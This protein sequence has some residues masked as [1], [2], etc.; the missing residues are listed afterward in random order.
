M[1]FAIAGS[2]AIGCRFGFMLHEIGIDVILIDK[3]KEHV[4]QIRKNGLKVNYNNEDKVAQIPIYY[5]E[6]VHDE[7]DVVIVFTKSMGLE[8]MLRDIKHILRKNTKIV[9]L[10]NGIGHEKV[11]QK[12]V[13][14][15]NILLGVT[16]FTAS[17]DG[18]GKVIL[19]GGGLTEIQNFQKGEKEEEVTREIVKVLDQA[20]LNTCFSE[21]V[22][23][24]IWRKA[25]VNGAMNA[26][27]A[28]LDCNLAEFSGTNEAESIIRGIVQEFVLIA[29]K[30]DIVLNED[31]IVQYTLDSSKKAGEHYPSMHQD[32]IQN[33][34]YT[35]VDFLNGAVDK[36]AREHG[37]ETPY[38]RLISLLIHAKEQILSVH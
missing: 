33:H 11:L 30:N 6:E 31:D 38:N 12:Y 16:I 32:L 18:P 26:T 24:S 29:G 36:L 15:E 23:F 21:N 2:G 8:E 9:S 34:R 19:H 10:L 35:E 5:P 13:L 14:P 28:L 1:K 20:G 27:C 25:C 22:K 4:E 7:I 3:W 37:V 17:L